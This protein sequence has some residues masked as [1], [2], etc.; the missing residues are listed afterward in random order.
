MTMSSTT[1]MRVAADSSARRRRLASGMTVP[2]G[3]AWVGTTWIS[4]GW[5]RP[6]RSSSTST[7]APCSSTGIGTSLAPA[8][9]SVSSTP[10]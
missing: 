3:L 4:R 5:T 2:P 7:R 9:R 1:G 10:G 8:A 6:S